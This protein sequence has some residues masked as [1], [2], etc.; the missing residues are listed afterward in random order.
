MYEKINFQDWPI[1]SKIAA[2]KIGPRIW[3]IAYHKQDEI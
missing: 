3:D 2:K 1:D